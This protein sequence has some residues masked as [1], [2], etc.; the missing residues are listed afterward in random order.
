MSAFCR[1][2]FA[3]LVLV[4]CGSRSEPAV[5]PRTICDGSD[6]LR[7]WAGVTG[8]GMTAVEHD[9]LFENGAS[10]FLIDGRCRFWVKPAENIFEEVR[11][12]VLD[13]GTLAELAD[14]FRYDHWPELEGSYFGDVAAFDAD[15]IGFMDRE[16]AISCA[17]NC[18][19]D[20]TPPDVVAMREA[21]VAWST[22]L[23]ETGEAV[24][25]DLRANAVEHS[26]PPED[27]SR[28]WRPVP[29]PASVPIESF[30]V[31]EG[32]GRPPIVVL[33]GPDADALRVLRR[34]F[35]DGEHGD[36]PSAG[37]SML[38]S[39]TDG[40]LYFVNVRDTTPFEDERGVIS[41]LPR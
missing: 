8:G 22:R 15:N 21:Y 6:D 14:D 5:P 3:L 37:H 35:L 39:D 31:P 1:A 7:F 25:G 29:W 40:P 13:P 41:W 9:V 18:L 4:G 33:S 38:I 12:G 28:E 20:S 2:V 19:G 23:W 24:S 32:G 11:S 27:W 17:A 16:V 10:F 26:R 36:F 34:E 30:A